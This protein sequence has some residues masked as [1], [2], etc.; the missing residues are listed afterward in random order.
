MA[1]T[2]I[3]IQTDEMLIKDAEALFAKM[4]L[5]LS[6]ATNVFYRQAVR[7]RGIP[8]LVTTVEVEPQRQARNELGEV[9]RAIQYDSVSNGTDKVTMDEINDIIAET[10]KK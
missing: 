5:T 4:G 1:Q 9:L 6:A 7:T 8:F 2:S 3:S 10:R